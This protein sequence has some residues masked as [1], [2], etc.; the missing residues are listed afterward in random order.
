MTEIEE[1]TSFWQPILCSYHQG[2]TA[3]PPYMGL[4]ASLFTTI[5]QL[6]TNSGC[7][8]P[9][10]A[11]HHSRQ[12][13]LIEQLVNMRADE[14]QSLMELLQEFANPNARY[15]T[16][17]TE[18]I[19]KASLGSDH[20]WSD[21]GLPERPLLGR[22][23]RYYFPELHARNTKNMRW[24]RFFYKQLC[25]RGGDYVCRAPSCEVCSSYNECFGPE[26]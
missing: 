21:L 3:L 14:K 26:E 10:P 5:K 23:I 24:K 13:D 16:E 7:R 18:V 4:P 25:E 20:L 17:M 8:F 6:L 12:R 11:Q 15:A 22:L 9:V 1:L 19:A 2:A